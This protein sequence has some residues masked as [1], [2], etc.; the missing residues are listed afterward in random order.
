MK[1]E[2]KR[3]YKHLSF[4]ERFVIEKLIK[5]QV[6]LREIARFLNRSPNTIREIKRNLVNGTYIADKARH[7]A[8]YKRWRS[9]KQCLKVTTD[10]FLHRFVDRKLRERWS[11]EQIAGYLREE[12]GI[13]CSTKA[14]Y[15]FARKRC[16]DRY[17]FWGWNKRKSGPKSWRYEKQNDDRVYIDDRPE[18]VGLGHFEM[19][20][21]VSKQSTWVLLVLVDR[22]SRNTLVERLPNRKHATVLGALSGMLR[23]VNVRSITTDN[24]IAFACWKK[25]EDILG[26]QVY[27]T[28]PYHSWEKGLVENTNRWIRCFVPKR[29][30][31]GLVTEKELWNIHSFLNDRPRKCIGYKI[32]SVYH[33]QLTTSN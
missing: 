17:L 7:R 10:N 8:Y 20:F 4:E 9:K 30:D 24:D 33:Y 16:Y 14:I 31:I 11:P 13:M 27:F 26:T 6:V 19:D 18:L 5:A 23:G 25:I 3:K 15:T 2:V 32:P 21:I 29:M 1:K 28:H 12:I 22:L